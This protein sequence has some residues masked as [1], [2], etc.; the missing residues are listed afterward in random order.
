MRMQRRRARGWFEGACMHASEGSRNPPLSRSM[1]SKS[2]S[3][4]VTSSAPSPS[5]GLR[6][7]MRNSIHVWAR[8]GGLVRKGGKGGKD[9]AHGRGA[10]KDT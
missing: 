7:D 9:E 2:A 10:R 6:I 8:A 3:S 1:R 4:S 5:L